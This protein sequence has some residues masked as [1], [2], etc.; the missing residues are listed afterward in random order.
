MTIDTD[1]DRR[2]R[3]VASISDAHVQC[4]L[5]QRAI[6]ELRKSR[7][8]HRSQLVVAI[9]VLTDTVGHLYAALAEIP[10]RSKPSDGWIGVG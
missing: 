4:E 3:V 2:T 1:S 5:A 7:T 8:I 9:K 6:D 10:E